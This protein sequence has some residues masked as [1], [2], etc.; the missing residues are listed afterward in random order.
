MSKIRECFTSRHEGGLLLE[1]DYSQLEIIALAHLSGDPQMY[2]DIKTGV[3]L[4]TV[5]AAQMYKVL[6]KQV[7]PQQRQ[8]AKVFSFQLQYGS[9]AKNMAESCKVDV[10]MAKEFIRLYYGRYPRVKEWQDEVAAEYAARRRP[11]TR[12]TPNGVTAGRSHHL[13][14]TGRRYVMYED[15]N[16][17]FGQNK[18]GNE[19]QSATNFS[20]TKMKNYPVQGFATGDIVPMMLGEVF[21]WL[22]ADKRWTKYKM[23]NT[24]HDSILFDIPALEGTNHAIFAAELKMLLESAPLHLKNYFNIN[25][26]LPLKVDIKTGKNWGKMKQFSCP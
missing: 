3:D 23:I 15:D 25:F 10:A 12:V 8:I 2:N 19:I 18:W 17:Y 7:T 5:R 9:G 21:K 11:S 13:S 26:D 22:K 16:P 4:H 24:V 14:V 6:E 20:P 1:A